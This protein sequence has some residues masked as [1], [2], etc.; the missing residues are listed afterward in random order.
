MHLFLQVL[1]TG[2]L[3]SADDLYLEEQ[4]SGD[5]SIDDEEFNS[6]SGSGRPNSSYPKSTFNINSTKSQ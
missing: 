1:V 3:A 2:Q 5:Y 4:Q 6:G